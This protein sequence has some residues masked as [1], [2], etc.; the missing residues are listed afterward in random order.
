MACTTYTCDRYGIDGL[1]AACSH[2]VCDGMTDSCVCN[3]GYQSAI[4]FWN[5]PAYDCDTSTSFIVALSVILLMQGGLLVLLTTWNLLNIEDWRRNSIISTKN[6]LNYHWCI[7]GILQIIWGIQKIRDP[8]NNLVG[9]DSLTTLSVMAIAFN[10]AGWCSFLGVLIMFL[11]GS[12]KM[13]SPSAK[14]MFQALIGGWERVLPYWEAV[15]VFF[16][17]SLLI[18]VGVKPSAG[19]HILIGWYC[20]FFFGMGALCALHILVI[21]QFC[22][23]LELFLKTAD[24]TG[25]TIVDKLKMLY[26]SLKIISLGAALF[27]L[28]TPLFIAF[29]ASP[30]LRHKSQYLLMLMCSGS[31]SFVSVALIAQSKRPVWLGRRGTV[32]RE[33]SSSSTITS[34]NRSTFRLAHFFHPARVVVSNGD[35]SEESLMDSLRSSAPIQTLTEMERPLEDPSLQSPLQMQ[36]R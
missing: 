13:F 34:Y 24:S 29:A 11:R 23:E 1:T 16:I 19:S 4:D 31:G 32:D 35:V 20:F 28:G 8:V 36:M 7:S 18:A 30:Y 22:A 21:S 25:G 2:G 17:G 27:L 6:R 26:W 9:K 14:E 3:E 12:F 10:M 15:F 5:D 33:I